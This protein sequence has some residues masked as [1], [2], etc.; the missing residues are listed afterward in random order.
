MKIRFLNLVVILLILVSCESDEASEPILVPEVH[1]T[2][3]FFSE[4]VEGSSFNKAVEIVNL[5][6]EDIDL[7]ETGYS[8]RKQSNGTGDWQADFLLIGILPNHEV[9]VVRNSNSDIP[10]IINNADQSKSGAPMDFNGN[11]PIGLFKNGILVDIIGIIDSP[12]DFGKDIT[13]RRKKEITEPSIDFKPEEWNIYEID[14][15]ED[16]GNY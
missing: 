2:D 10:E 9:H 11:D 4:Y 8:L 6:G 3:L 1:S 13:L 12:E 16:L 7:S 5:T 14:N 15:I